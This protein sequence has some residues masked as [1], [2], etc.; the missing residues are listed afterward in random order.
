M[1]SRELRFGC[2]MYLVPYYANTWAVACEKLVYSGVVGCPGQRISCDVG[3]I[4]WIS[5]P[6]SLP[7]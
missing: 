2:E 5:L 3:H 4:S 1:P 7:A 6:A